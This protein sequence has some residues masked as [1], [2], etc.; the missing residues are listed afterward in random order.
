MTMRS[1]PRFHRLSTI[2]VAVTVAA[3]ALTGCRGQSNDTG[4]DGGSAANA[5]GVTADSIK[6]GGSFPFSGGLALYGGLSK[7]LQ[8]YFQQVNAEGGVN[9]R[10]ID[11]TALEDA[12]DPSRLASNARQLVE[13]DQVFAFVSFGGTNLAIRDY[14]KGQAV[15]QFVMAGNAPLSDIKTYPTTRAWWPDIRLEGAITARTILDKSPNAKIGVL[16]LNNDITASQ[17][18]GV[19][20]GLDQHT[21]QLVATET[22]P[23]SATD[24]SGQ[25]NRLKAA[26]VDTLIAGIGGPQG[27]NA[28]QY[29]KQTGWAP[30]VYN[31]SNAS[32][33]ATFVGQAGAAA[34]GMHSV[35]WM[36]DPAD[37]Q[38]ANDEGIKKFKDAV[39]KYG[40]GADPNNFVVLNGYAFG[41]ALV[42]VLKTI[43]N[44]TRD[45]LIKAWD[46]VQNVEN[47]ALLP[48]VKLSAG[49][50]GRLV[51]SYRMTTWDGTTWK[52]E[53]D[54]I[55]ATKL[56]LLK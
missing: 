30:Q 40:D 22:Y 29:M 53:G 28:V 19:K 27:I 6:I 24:L 54:V 31:Y 38:W 43:K 21:N 26:G 36:K 47:A 3:L 51:H 23:P 48:G 11:Y 1:R 34:D 35:Q 20:D 5:P 10:K 50:D 14:M 41:Q 18:E 52:L 44:P 42:G 46:G 2:A 12:Y 39:Q 32:T 7:G 55:D 17:V 15:P 13:Q 37:P 25:V 9:G 8:A 49:S 33:I 4:G 16:G 45:G 56:G